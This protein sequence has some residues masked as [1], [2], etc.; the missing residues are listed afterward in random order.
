[1]TELIY[2]ENI[3]YRVLAHTIIVSPMVCYLQAGDT[4]R[5]GG[6]I[7]SMFEGLRSGENYI[8]SRL[9]PEKRAQLRQ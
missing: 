3:C 9:R 4:R 8:N 1:M 7:H 6:I 5:V 2:K